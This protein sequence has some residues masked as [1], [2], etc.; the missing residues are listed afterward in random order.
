MLK[1]RFDPYR[2]YS[3]QAHGAATLANI[4]T[5]SAKSEKSVAILADVAALTV[6]PVVLIPAANASP[7]G[8]P[9]DPVD[10]PEWFD[11][12]AA[13]IEFDDKESRERAELLAYAETIEAWC[14]RYWE[15]PTKR[16]CASCGKPS[17]SF[18][19]G[20]GA[21]V[22]RATNHTCLVKYGVKRKQA[23][24][25]WL[26]KINIKPPDGWTYPDGYMP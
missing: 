5:Q 6:E 21:Y 22:C 10:W 24:V 3:Q 7:F 26:R 12:R 4:A 13:I 18:H 17:P 20:D 2:H 15:V 16:T 25:K 11:E 19:C 9:N 14:A 8:A 23:A 1:I